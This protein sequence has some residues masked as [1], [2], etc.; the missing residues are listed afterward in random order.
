MRGSEERHKQERRREEGR[1]D[2]RR[3]ISVVRRAGALGRAVTSRASEGREGCP[4]SDRAQE[5]ISPLGTGKRIVWIVRPAQPA[6]PD[7]CS[8]L[9]PD[10]C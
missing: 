1:R 5:V 3:R 8:C 4:C 10:D 6:L 7:R 9:S 2:R